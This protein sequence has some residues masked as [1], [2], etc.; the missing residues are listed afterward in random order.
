MEFAHG[1]GAEGRRAVVVRQRQ[2]HVRR[3]DDVVEVESKEPA[4]DGQH[5]QEGGLP[6][7]WLGCRCVCSCSSSS[8]RSRRH[9]GQ[10]PRWRAVRPQAVL[11][12]RAQGRWSVFNRTYAA[13]MEWCT[14]LGKAL[15][16]REGCFGYAVEW[17]GKKVR[18]SCVSGRLWAVADRLVCSVHRAAHSAPPRVKED[19]RWG[20]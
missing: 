10:S 13:K 11:G 15:V 2:V 1:E 9:D 19:G 16:S 3:L 14:G 18:L 8:G 20:L 17:R 7:C 6:P 5:G 12:G 4:G